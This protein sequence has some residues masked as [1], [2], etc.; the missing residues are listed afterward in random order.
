MHLDG[1][2][3]ITGITGDGQRC[4][5]F[6]AGILGLSYEGRDRDFEAPGSHL[7]RL[8]GDPDRPGGTLSFIEAPGI[9]HGDPGSGM[10]H[11]VSWAVRSPA[12]LEY[13]SHRLSDAGI[14]ASTTES[15][16]RARQVRF[17][18][19]DGLE[20][21]L[22]VEAPEDGSELVLSSAGVARE[23]AIVRL[24]GVRAF[25]RERIPSADILAGRLGFRVT[26]P[27]SYT[28]GGDELRG[29]FAFDPP[30]SAR[31]RLGTGTIHH[32]A[33]ACDGELPA[34]R[35]RVI[36][37]G[38]RVTPVIDRG[39]CRSIYFREPSGVL[40]E[41]ATRGH[42]IAAAASPATLERLSPRVDPR[43]HAAFVG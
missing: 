4:V 25:G 31:A 18:D 3:H 16:D 26:G 12:S 34:W 43:F 42:D 8:G 21:L 11:A 24:R 1:I 30:P 40:F 15:N 33:W 28:V 14:E 9:G 32:V 36:G 39:H 38:C 23:H 29:D 27:D 2:H 22:S 35:Q 6:Y 13:W 10:V 17:A 41:I 20:H 5:D 7:I 19:P 37:M